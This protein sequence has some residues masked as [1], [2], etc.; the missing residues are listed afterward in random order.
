MRGRTTLLWTIKAA[1]AGLIVGVTLGVA[2]SLTRAQ[3]S[4]CVD[5]PSVPNPCAGCGAVTT[6]PDKA[7]C[8]TSGGDTLQCQTLPCDR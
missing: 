5:C 8:S 2:T 4:G 7:C 3:D 6:A 1:A